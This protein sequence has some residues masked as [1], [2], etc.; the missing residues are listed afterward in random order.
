MLFFSLSL[1]ALRAGPLSTYL[2]KALSD[3][4]DCCIAECV[5]GLE[6]FHNLGSDCAWYSSPCHR[7]ALQRARSP[8]APLPSSYCIRISVVAIIHSSFSC[9]KF[10][11]EPTSVET[12]TLPRQLRS[13]RMHSN[14]RPSK[15]HNAQNALVKKSP[16]TIPS[17]HYDCSLPPAYTYQSHSLH[18]LQLLAAIRRLPAH[19]P[20]DLEAARPLQTVQLPFFALSVFP[21]AQRKCNSIF[22]TQ[23]SFSSSHSPL[24][25]TKLFVIFFSAPNS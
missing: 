19:H 6:S 4:H 18:S 11:K 9:P 22:F 21:T 16:Q 5:A 10:Q 20:Q 12:V 25:S 7:R 8:V 17:Q 2:S 15:M 23:T 3:I 14:T 13:E 1:L 24:N